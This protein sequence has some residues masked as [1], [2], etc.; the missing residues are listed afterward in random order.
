MTF[1]PDVQKGD[2]APADD[3]R[4][5]PTGKS[6]P[7]SETPADVTSIKNREIFG[8]VYRGDGGWRSRLWHEIV[9]RQSRSSEVVSPIYQEDEIEPGTDDTILLRSQLDD[10]DI[11]LGAGVGSAGNNEVSSYWVGSIPGDAVVFSHV[12]R[13]DW[14]VDSLVV[15]AGT[16]PASD[17]DI[18]IDIGATQRI[19]TLGSGQNRATFDIS[20]TIIAEEELRVTGQSAADSA[21]EDFRCSFDLESN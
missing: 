3:Q 20:T 8:V 18:T 12:V 14:L 19:K 16:A 11:S 2:E 21:I 9:N 5:G 15:M 10:L 4:L 6:K 1:Q 7:P 17:F 13:H